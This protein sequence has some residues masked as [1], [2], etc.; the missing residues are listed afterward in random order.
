[1]SEYPFNL[2]GRQESFKG[3]G[4]KDG[5]I[6]QS[7]EFILDQ[8]VVIAEI[9]HHGYGDFKLS[10]V[11]SEDFKATVTRNIAKTLGIPLYFAGKVIADAIARIVWTPV[12]SEGKIDTWVINQVKEDKENRLLRSARRILRRYRGYIKQVKE[13]EEIFLPPGEYRLEVKSKSRWTCRFIQPDLDQSSDSIED[14]NY[15]LN[16]DGQDAGV[17]VLG[18][19]ESG[20]RPMLAHI[21]HSGRGEF[22]AAAH[23]VDGTHQCLIFRQEGQFIVEDQQTEIRPGKEYFFYVEADGEWNIACTGGY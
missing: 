12:D 7:R 9:A 15:G 4:R 23:S 10:F 2:R 5:G 21:R 22:Y 19:L 17:H 14:E 3:T 20:S 16:G 11:P 18:P 6:E 1:M 13:D 8:G